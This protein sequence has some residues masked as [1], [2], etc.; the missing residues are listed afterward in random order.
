[1]TCDERSV[2]TTSGVP[3][4]SASAQNGSRRVDAAR[5]HHARQRQRKERH[6]RALLLLFAQAL[7]VAQLGFAQHLD[8]RRHDAVQVPDQHQARLLNASVRDLA[9]EPGRAADQPHVE[10]QVRVVE[11]L[12]HRDRAKRLRRGLVGHPRLTSLGGRVV[13]L[14]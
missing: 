9:P 6:G 10:P 2:Q 12:S 1:M 8:A 3:V 4:R 5:H 14:D 11:Q 13:R 7:G